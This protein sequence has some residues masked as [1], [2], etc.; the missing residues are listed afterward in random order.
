MARTIF[1]L[2]GVVWVLV[3]ERVLETVEQLTLKNPDDCTARKST[4]PA[5]R[6]EGALFALTSLIGGKAHAWVLN[7]I[8]IGG[9]L[10]IFFPK[11]SLD[12]STYLVYERPES[13]AWK[14]GFITFVRCM[15]V[16]YILIAATA[17]RRRNRET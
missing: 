2:L 13:V 10:A 16:L 1:G 7:L 6:A 14:D 17:F 8:G 12:F 4:I 11:Q 15:G 3:P 9:I 5:I